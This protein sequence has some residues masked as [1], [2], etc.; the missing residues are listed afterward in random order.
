MNVIENFV[1]TSV[2]GDRISFRVQAHG[3]AE[4]L[5]RALRFEGLIEEERIDV[6]DFDIVQAVSTLDFFYSP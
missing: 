2:E 6:S 1:I 3:G 4:R 5:A